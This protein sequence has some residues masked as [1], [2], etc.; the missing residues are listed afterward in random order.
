VEQVNEGE[1]LGGAL[2]PQSAKNLNYTHIP[3]AKPAIARYSTNICF[4]NFP[5]AES[6]HR[7]DEE[8]K[9]ILWGWVTGRNLAE[10]RETLPQ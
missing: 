3:A 8:A 7:P 6:I 5:I 9:N 1:E 10:M 2:K 4:S